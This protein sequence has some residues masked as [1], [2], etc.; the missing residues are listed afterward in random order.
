MLDIIAMPGISM[1][2]IAMSGIAINHG[3]QKFVGTH[4]ADKNGDKKVG[5]YIKSYAMRFAQCHRMAGFTVTQR[6]SHRRGDPA[7]L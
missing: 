4:H 2:G 7:N 6:T 1:S 3:P 5:I